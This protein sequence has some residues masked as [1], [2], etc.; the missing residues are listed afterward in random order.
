MNSWQMAQQLKAVLE[1]LA[2]PSGEQDLVFGGRGSVSIY[3]GS[4]TDEQVPPGFPWAMVGIGSAT[5]DQD[6]PDFVQQQFSVSV[7]AEVA[8]DR[9]GE[10]AIIGGS[11]RA[12]GRSA[13]RGV[14]EIAYRVRERVQT[15]T[16]MDGAHLIVSHTAS[17]PVAVLGRGRH[18]VMLEM[19]LTAWCSASPYYAPP[20]QLRHSGGAWRW[21]GGLCSTRY[22][23]LRFIL[24]R[25]T[26][27]TIPTSAS[28]GTVLYSGS[29]TQFTG[30]STAGNVYAV[31]AEYG[32]RGST[33]D[34]Y[35]GPVVGAYRIVT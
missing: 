9:M 12:A 20:Q 19:D 11:V 34:A 26:G 4:P 14:A 17:Q 22:D 28:D 23:F 27:A 1:A 18:A 13:G 25:K 16:G 3:A 5:P 35:S 31:F 6:H 2:W 32:S 21:E 10:H 8:G 15:M 33:V 24:L 7:A 29:A 30:A